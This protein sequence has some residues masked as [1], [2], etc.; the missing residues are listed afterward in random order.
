MVQVVNKNAPA[1]YH[2]IGESSGTY[3]ELIE[4]LR[5]MP[6]SVDPKVTVVTCVPPD[7][8]SRSPLIYQLVNSGVK[9]YNITSLDNMNKVLKKINSMYTMV[10]DGIHCIFVRDVA[11]FNPQNLLLYYGKEVIFDCCVSDIDSYTVNFGACLGTTNGLKNFY[12]I[13]NELKDKLNIEDVMRAAFCATDDVW[14]D[15]E[16]RFFKVIASNTKILSEG[17]E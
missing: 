9:H 2:F 4:V 15:T 3:P 1:V 6:I 17:E 5:R 13:V 14:I 10:L 16:F 12:K 8:V 7:L 11:H